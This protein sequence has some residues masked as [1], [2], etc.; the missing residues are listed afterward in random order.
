MSPLTFT[1]IAKEVETEAK[2][3]KVFCLNESMTLGLAKIGLLLEKFYGSPRD[4]EWA[5]C[6]NK[7][8]ILQARSVTSLNTFS[9]FELL[10][11]FDNAVM[12]P[13]DFF[14][15]ANIGEALPGAVSTL[16]ISVMGKLFEKSIRKLIGVTP[17]SLFQTCF[18]NFSNQLFLNAN[19][20]SLKFVGKEISVG[21]KVESLAVFGYDYITP[22][23]HKVALHRNKKRNAFQGIAMIWG[24][25]RVS[26]NV[27]SFESKNH[28]ESFSESIEYRQNLKKY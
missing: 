8:Y 23:I 5:I 16:S 21:N 22:E 20:T 13:E 1:E 14:T 11:E 2:R 26:F 12:S 24:V 4:V 25:L 28:F 6:R 9:N 19:Q 3:Q 18:P 17:S 15:R 7:I 27:N 10:H